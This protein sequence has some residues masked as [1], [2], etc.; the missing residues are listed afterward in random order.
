MG[1]RS[2]P[3]R[4]ANRLDSAHADALVRSARTPASSDIRGLSTTARM[5][6]PIAVERSRNARARTTTTVITVVESSSPLTA[7]PARWK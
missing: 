2:T 1:A 4:P 5:R 6:R 7:E 3:A